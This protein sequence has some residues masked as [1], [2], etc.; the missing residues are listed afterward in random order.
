VRTGSSPF[1]RLDPDAGTWLSLATDDGLL[2]KAG[3]DNLLAILGKVDIEITT[4][5]NFFRR[6]GF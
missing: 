3:T 5:G 6:R 2:N 1:E 4:E